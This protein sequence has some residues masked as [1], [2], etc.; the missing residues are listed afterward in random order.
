[1]LRLLLTSCA[2]ALVPAAPAVAAKTFAGTTGAGTPITLSVTGKRAA[3]NSS[4]A[5]ACVKTGGSSGTKAGI[6]LFRPTGT[7]ALNG[8][9]QQVGELLE[10]AV[11]GGRKVTI[12]HHLQAARKGRTISG[13]LSMNYSTSDYD[14]FTMSNTITVCDGSATFTARRR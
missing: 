7:F 3:V 1:M 5:M 8:T 10:S 14:V 13:E 11:F 2:L 12:N 6:E 9:D 4:L